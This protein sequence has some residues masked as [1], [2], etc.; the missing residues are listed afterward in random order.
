MYDDILCQMGKLRL[1][2]HITLPI[3]PILVTK[4]LLTPSAL[5]ATAGCV[6]KYVPLCVLSV[7]YHPVNA[8]TDNDRKNSLTQHVHRDVVPGSGFVYSKTRDRWAK[9]GP[10]WTTVRNVV[11]GRLRWP[12]TNR[13][14]NDLSTIRVNVRLSRDVP[15]TTGENVRARCAHVLL[16]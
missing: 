14:I 8:M 9:N 12:Q 1:N 4:H 11:D 5:V 13:D 10:V 15:S 7:E 2:C 6:Q 16:W 3:H